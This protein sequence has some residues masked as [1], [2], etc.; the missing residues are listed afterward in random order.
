MLF[1]DHLYEKLS[2]GLLLIDSAEQITEAQKNAVS[3]IIQGMLLSNQ[4]HTIEKSNTST[5][6][7]PA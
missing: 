2:D 5:Q 6:E 3:F 1:N 4:V 7:K